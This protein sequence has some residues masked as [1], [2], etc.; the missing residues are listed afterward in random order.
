MEARGDCPRCMLGSVPLA[1]DSVEV[2]DLTPAL[3]EIEQ[4]YI[5]SPE[6]LNQPRKSKTAVRACRMSPDD[7]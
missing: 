6:F 4:R 5:G 7:Q 3:R 1:G 2:F